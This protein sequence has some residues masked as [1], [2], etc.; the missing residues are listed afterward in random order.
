MEHD[1]GFTL[2]ELLVVM[3]IVGVLAAVA[4]PTFLTAKAKAQEAAVKSDIK[5]VA[6]EVI[7]YYVD[8]TGPLTVGTS[9]D[10]R[11]WQVFDSG[12]TQVAA[13]PLS[14]HNS[15]VSGG[16]IA[17]DH[18]YCI[19]ILPTYGEARAGRV[20]QDGLSLGAC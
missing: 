4:I 7:A 16:S 20:T 10:G 17:S 8:G 13:G 14:Q 9:L 1:D 2:I 18:A 5:Q 6:K 15:V 3:V 11:S 12:S 19:S